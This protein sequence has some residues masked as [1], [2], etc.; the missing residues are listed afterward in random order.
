MHDSRD[1]G[2]GGARGTAAEEV[3]Q[4]REQ[5]PTTA[6]MQEVG[7]RRERLPRRSPNKPPAGGQLTSL[8][9]GPAMHIQSLSTRVTL[10]AVL[11]AVSACTTAKVVSSSGGG[12]TI[13]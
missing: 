4:R 3:G 5:L 9:E 10:F 13:P 8:K 2:G 1:G 7:Q 6:W 12:P 11:L